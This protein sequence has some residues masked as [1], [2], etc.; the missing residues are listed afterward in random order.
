MNSHTNTKHEAAT[1]TATSITKITNKF[2][3]EN[4]RTIVGLYPVKEEHI[5]KHL[6]DDENNNSK[7]LIRTA[8]DF[9]HKELG[10]SWHKIKEFGIKNVYQSRR[11]EA[12]TIYLTL[13]SPLEVSK[14]FR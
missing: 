2:V 10:L 1:T 5:S 9:L 12:K 8:K 3:L 6:F 14:I 13:K 4:A 11:E 7:A